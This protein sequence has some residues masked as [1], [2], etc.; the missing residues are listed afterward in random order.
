[1]GSADLKPYLIEEPDYAWLKDLG[2]NVDNEGAFDGAW[3]GKGE[4]IDTFCPTNGRP[5]ARVRQASVDDY[6]LGVGKAWEA[7]SVWSEV[8]APKR[9]EIVR[10]IGEGLR[11]K[12]EALGKLESLEMGKILPEGIGNLKHLSILKLIFCK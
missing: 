3:G 5:I 4:W 7:W 2:L 12:L 8:P 1:M 11:Q 10:Q 9:G 6:N